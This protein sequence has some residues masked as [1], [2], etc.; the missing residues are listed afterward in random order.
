MWIQQAPQWNEDYTQSTVGGWRNTAGDEYDPATY[1]SDVDYQAMLRRGRT[2]GLQ[3]YLG[4]D[5]GLAY[6]PNPQEG[7]LESF[8]AGGQGLA[9]TPEMI[10]QGPQKVIDDIIR[11][12]GGPTAAASHMLEGMM[13]T[14][15]FDQFPGWNEQN[16]VELNSYIRAM[17]TG[18][19]PTTLGMRQSEFQT[20]SVLAGPL[21][22]GAGEA[23]F[24]GGELAG[25][26]GTETLLGGAGADTLGGGLGELATGAGDM[27][28]GMGE[29]A[30]EGLTL[31]GEGGLTALQTAGVAGAGGAA[32]D[33][34]SGTALDQADDLNRQGLEEFDNP[35]GQWEPDFQGDPN[36][37]NQTKTI[38]DTLSTDLLKTL[39]DTL[40]GGKDIDW[41]GIGTDLYKLSGQKEYQQGLLDT[42]NR[43]V[44]YSDPFHNER[45][46][47]QEQFKNMNTNPNWMDDDAVLN[48]IQSNAMRN[49]AAQNSAKGYI[50]SGNILHDLTRTGTETAAQYAIPRMELSGRAAG[51]FNNPG[52]TGN[53][54]STLG[55][56]AGQAG[57][58]QNQTVGSIAG[59][60]GNQ[61]NRAIQSIFDSIFRGGGNNSYAD[62]LPTEGL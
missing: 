15:Y 44:D 53:I 7:S 40:T 37:T 47:Y 59:R 3:N 19:N 31:G 25:A 30:T 50:N 57:L 48:A 33:E 52:N 49:V 28:G 6:N 8:G 20:A 60:F 58:A 10:A 4:V 41:L 9:P 56:M 55:P 46:F 39:K 24:G 17:Q 12:H 34:L 5:P 43:A 22:Y 42:M 13:K 32:V 27:F 2:D 16:N 1:M 62:G 38:W 21:M 11:A 45:P 35:D 29:F 26:G 36:L 51:A 61:G 54:L 23:A 14:G 18:E